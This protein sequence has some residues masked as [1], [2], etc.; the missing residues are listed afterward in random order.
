MVKYIQ[1]DSHDFIELPFT[2][3]TD[4][5][6]MK[7]ENKIRKALFFLF[8]EGFTQTLRKHS[9]I[10]IEKQSTAEQKIIVCEFFLDDYRLIGI[11]RQLYRDKLKKFHSRMLFRVKPGVQFSL[12]DFTLNEKTITQNFGYLPL[13]DC[14]LNTKIP[15]MIISQNPSLAPLDIEVPDNLLWKPKKIINENSKKVFIYGFGA[16]SRVYSLKY[17]R[18]NINSIIDY[19]KNVVTAYKN[20]KNVSYFED[21]R[22]SLP[23]YKAIQNPIAIIST[24]HSSHFKIA[25]ALFDANPDGKVFIEKPIV[26]EFDDALELMELKKKGFWCEAGYNRRYIDWNREIKNVLREVKEPKIINISVKELQIPSFHWY[27]WPNQGTRITGN[28]SHWI[29]LA[30]FWL[31]CKPL[32]MTLLNSGDSVSLNIYFE[33]GSI[34]N[35]IAS[36]IGNSLRG[37]QERIE[38]RTGDKTFFIDDYRKMIL[39]D[40]GKTVVKRKISRDK[41]HDKMYKEFLIATKTDSRP[42][43]EEDDIF[44]VSYLIEK[45]SRMLVNK[46]RHIKVDVD[47]P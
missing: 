45:A 19:N 34:V 32:E 4:Y 29:D 27:F 17:F 7:Y 15:D 40:N 39:Y 38:I 23:Y 20:S 3:Y 13:D 28:V 36:D 25:K 8:S 14:P 6:G 46:Q 44:W 22:D 12:A 18:D 2:G 42:Q 1:T 47:Y 33:D 16:Y 11:G 37:V 26:V 31:K 30:Y 10:Q 35:I 9:S 41:G 5:I 21:F 24:Y 43:Y